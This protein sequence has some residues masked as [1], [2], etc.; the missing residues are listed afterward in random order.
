M[1]RAFKEDKIHFEALEFGDVKSLEKELRD[2]GE[3]DRRTIRKDMAE[4][5]DY[6]K[7]KDPFRESE[8]TKKSEKRFGPH[9]EQPGIKGQRN[10]DNQIYFR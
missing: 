8:K 9:P 2:L 7:K 5:D 4:I 6:L 3:K 1:A 10:S